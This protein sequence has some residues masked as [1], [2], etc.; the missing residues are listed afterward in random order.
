MMITDKNLGRIEVMTIPVPD[1]YR[2]LSGTY[3]F[4]G[5]VLLHC[6]KEG[7]ASDQTQLLVMEDDGSGV[8]EI[9]DGT[10]P[11]SRHANGIRFMPFYDD[12]RI[13]LGDSILECEPDI[14]DCRSCRLISLKY[15]WGIAEDDTIFCHWSEIIIS[16]DNEHI[17]WTI[18]GKGFT[19]ACLGRLVRREDCYE[20][21]DGVVLN[22][23]EISRPDPEHPGCSIFPVMKGGEVKQ[24]VHG[25]LGISAVGAVTPG[26]ADSVVFDL[27]ADRTE[28]ITRTPGYEETTMFSPDETLGLVMSPRFSLKTSL[29]IFG[30]LPRPGGAAATMGLARYLYSYSVSAVRSFRKGNIGPALIEIGRSMSEPGYPGV[31]LADREENWVYCPPLSWHPDSCRGMW[32]EVERGT[33]HHRLRRVRLLDRTPGAPVKAQ[34]TPDILPFG[35][36]YEAFRAA[37]ARQKET[38]ERHYRVAGKAG[39]FLEL[40]MTDS[41][42]ETVYQHYTDDGLTFWDGRETLSYSILQDTVYCADVSMTGHQTGQMQLRATFTGFAARRLSLSFAPAADGKPASFGYASFGGV[43]RTMEELRED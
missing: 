43:T 17:S 22:E 25:G 35:T 11:V 16:P 20:I 3:T 4:A 28:Q 24:F 15:P 31:C 9:F 2:P 6:Q 34:A 39:G 21:V 18:L 1:G 40:T 27:T 10:F 42:T 37:A 13:L 32:N 38:P 19:A 23:A 12:T 33:E 14:S 26:T 7:S 5:K 8:R 30:T 29:A 41:R 36:T